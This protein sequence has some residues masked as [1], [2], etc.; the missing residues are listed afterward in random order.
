MFLSPRRNNTYVH[1]RALLGVLH[2]CMK[3]QQ[4]IPIVVS[5]AA[6]LLF[7]PDERGEEGSS[8]ARSF[9]L[10]RAKNQRVPSFVRSSSSTHNRQY[11]HKHEAPTAHT[12]VLFKHV[13]VRTSVLARKLGLLRS[14]SACLH[15][16]HIR[17][18]LRRSRS[19]FLK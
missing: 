9:T 17:F 15:T 8:L 7:F 18:L 2:A 1:T 6:V 16:L 14:P 12:C 10:R 13:Y 11:L 4:R 19:C 3:K 5:T